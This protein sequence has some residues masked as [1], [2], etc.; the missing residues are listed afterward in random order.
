MLVVKMSIYVLHRHVYDTNTVNRRE[1]NVN[2]DIWDLRFSNLV[3]PKANDLKYRKDENDVLTF[4]FYISWPTVLLAD[5]TNEKHRFSIIHYQNF[6]L[7]CI[8][9]TTTRVDP[10]SQT[11]VMMGSD[12]VCVDVTHTTIRS[13]IRLRNIKCYL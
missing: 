2:R 8:E 11:A 6:T 13:S 9:K 4:L 12:C 10:N 3:Y 5:E 7:V 1:K